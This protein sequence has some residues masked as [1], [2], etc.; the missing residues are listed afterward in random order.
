MR[1][2]DDRLSVL[3]RERIDLRAILGGNAKRRQGSRIRDLLAGKKGETDPCD[4]VDSPRRH[5]ALHMQRQLPPKKHNFGFDSW[6][7][8]LRRTT[9]SGALAGIERAFSGGEGSELLHRTTVG[10]KAA[11]PHCLLSR[12]RCEGYFSPLCHLTKP[13]VVS[14]DPLVAQP[15]AGELGVLA[16]NAPPMKGL[17][18]LDASALERAWLALDSYVRTAVAT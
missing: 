2:R 13:E 7:E 8:L 1:S 12:V 16:L 14:D 15:D 17:E 3:D 5:A 4:G 6:I 11:F 10:L 18:Y 9:S